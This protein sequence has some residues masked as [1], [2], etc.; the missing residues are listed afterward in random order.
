M[1]ELYRTALRVRRGT[2]GLGDG[3]MAWLPSAPGVLAFTRGDSFA[4]VV[5][6]SARPTQLPAHREVILASGPLDDGRLPTDA[7]VWLRLTD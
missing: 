6:M 2:P 1:L 5:N 3:P 4:C 7:A